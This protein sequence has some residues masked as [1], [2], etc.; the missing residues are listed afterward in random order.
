MR[1]ISALPPSARRLRPGR[2]SGLWRI[3][4]AAW[5]AFGL[6]PRPAAAATILYKTDAELI[7]LSER[8]VHARVL[9]YR[10]ERPAD[11]GGA[12]YTVTTLAV[13]EDLTGVEG[14]TVEVWELGGI[15][16]REVMFVG[17]QV[18]Y[19]PG[20][21]VL[22]CLGRGRFGLHSVAMGFSKFDIASEQGADGSTDGRLVRGL[23]DTYVVGGTAS[24]QERSLSAFRALA[25]AVR[26]VPSVR[27]SSVTPFAPRDTVSEAFTL[28]TFGNGLGARWTEPDSNGPVRYYRN[29]SANSPLTSG[30]VDTEIGKALSAW[31]GRSGASLTLQYA[32]AIYQSDPYAPVSSLGT[33]LITF[34]DPR[35]EISNPTLSVGGGMA[36]VGDGGTVNGTPFNRFT[37]AFI[38]FQNAADLPV[39]FRDPVDFSRVL[40]HEVGHTIG[41]GHS[42]DT[43]AIMYASCCLSSTPVAPA[44]GQDDLAG[45]TFIY[46]SSA[47]TAC[48]VALS[49]TSVSV[50]AAATSG[51]VT[52]STVGG[53][54]W[55]AVSNAAFVAVDPATG[56]GSGVVTY[57][58]Q[59]NTGPDPRIAT[60]TIAAQSVTI[61]QAG[62]VS[63]NAPPF[64]VMDTP[65]DNAT[66]VTGSMPVTGWALDDEQVTAVKI[67]RDPV[68][69]EA[70][71][72]LVYIGDATF[73]PGAR[74]DV[75]AAYPTLPFNTRAGWGYLLLTSVL[76]N[77]G[78]GVFRLHAYAQD[79]LGH[80]TLLGMRTL[81]GAN[82][83]STTPFG[84]IDTPAQNGVVAGSA[85][86]NFGWVLSRGPRRADPPGGGTVRVVID[87][88]VVGSPSGWTNRSDLNALFPATLYPGIGTALGVYTF[89]TAGLTNG[90]HTIAWSVEDNLGSAAG[91]G[92]RYFTVA[93]AATASSAPTVPA[94]PAP[95]VDINH[96]DLDTGPIAERRGFSESTPFRSLYPDA[97]GLATLQAEEIDR[98]ELRLA[99][100]AG[101][102]A[103]YAGYLRTPAGLAPLPVGSTLD[104]S[105]GGFTWQPGPGFVGAYDLVFV[106]SI[107]GTAVARRDVRVV[108]L[109][110][111]SGRVGPQVVIDIPTRQQ[112]VGQP[113]VIAGWA[114]DAD[115]D[116]DT[117]V[118]A[119]HV[120]AYPLA[121]GA[122]V[123]TG[124]AAYGG[125]RPDVGAQYG[126][127]FSA[128][129]YSLT[130][131]GLRPGNYDLAVF[132]WSRLAGG[133]V[134]ATTVRVTVR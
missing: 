15:D 92:S 27:H 8:V 66:G 73:V 64:G 63:F 53:C 131:T 111:A 58:I 55:T 124:A 68:S 94:A 51:S 81:T 88:V 34:E 119:V 77:Q 89:S 41:L 90:L 20:T 125:L 6:L 74:P 32:G 133:F 127:R 91:I 67:Y 1:L 29:S 19:E 28:L 61:T 102:D 59:A 3:V 44:I 71:G 110:K 14:D 52:V 116:V 76:P 132:A 10:F 123:F 134:P 43:S 109:P 37:S 26:G 96:L 117:G 87:G 9:G 38:I 114:I 23:K 11:G 5:L 100:S 84:A 80:Q 7:A 105:S 95:D 97:S 108:L 12:I 35:D 56:N 48:T 47:P 93:S 126:Q 112:D 130:V 103:Q 45:L 79:R 42:A 57:T 22:V 75:A 107:A 122:P 70:A 65:L 98:I 128:S 104:A 18:R 86:N 31:T 60:L 21:E 25:A 24:D 118:E 72:T 113:F 120:W 115:E 39:S 33:T 121:G 129:G 17:G 30:N 62:L 4:F 36:S 83:T 99:S 49:P 16:G 13:I 54:G 101:G 69:P 50:A 46:P 40:E 106:R 78:T 82:S 85:Y 2:A